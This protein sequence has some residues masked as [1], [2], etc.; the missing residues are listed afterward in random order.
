MSWRKKAAMEATRQALT[1]MAETMPAPLAR[2]AA[3]TKQLFVPDPRRPGELIYIPK[4][5]G[6]NGQPTTLP[7][8]HSAARTKYNVNFIS[9]VVTCFGSIQRCAAR[10][11]R[12]AAPYP[13]SSTCA[14]TGLPGATRVKSG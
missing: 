11:S 10:C 3:R 13:P 14:R 6:R 8:L 9:A 2:E 5:N 1:I 7:L 4:G 12:T